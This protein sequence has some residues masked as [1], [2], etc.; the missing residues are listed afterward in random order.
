VRAGTAVRDPA[1]DPHAVSV[2]LLDP[3][4]YPIRPRAPLGLAGTSF[5]GSKI[6]AR[7][8]ADYVVLPFQLD[9]R[10]SHPSIDGTGVIQDLP[11][12][13]K[14][15]LPDPILRGADGHNF[16]YGFTVYASTGE[17]ATTGPV[18]TGLQNTVLRFATPTDAAAAAADMSSRSATFDAGTLTPLIPSR[19]VGI[20]RYPDAR[21]VAYDDAIQ[22][23]FVLS[24]TPHGPYLLIQ[25]AQSQG[26]TDAAAAVVAASL[27]R[28][29]PLIDTFAAT[30]IDQLAALPIDP[31]GLL[32]RLVPTRDDERTV[33]EGTFGTHGALAFTMSPLRDQ[34]LYTDTDMTL[35]AR[36]K[37]NVYQARDGA[38]AMAIVDDFA[39]DVATNSAGGWTPASPVAGMPSAKCLISQA[40]AVT[41][42]HVYCLAA[43]DRYAIEVNAGQE[44]D[45][46]QILAAQY[47]LLAAT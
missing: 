19:P 40:N 9:S 17:P 7:R 20:P 33:D 31:T 8:M 32:A 26:G 23:H 30:P 42:S 44:L 22:D 39:D 14:A 43:A 34:Q 18:S 15:S 13:A 37:T 35:M 38:G 45:A 27:D 21:A 11:A 12:L 29:E 3:G 16:I 6:D 47:L 28:Q 36:A 4:N 46:H 24:Y 2:A 41:S 1:D 5:A 10:M 25:E